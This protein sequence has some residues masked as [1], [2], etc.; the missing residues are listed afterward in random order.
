LNTELDGHWKPLT[1]AL[2]RNAGEGESFV[3]CLR[4]RLTLVNERLLADP[5]IRSKLRVIVQSKSVSQELFP[6]LLAGEGKG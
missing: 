2:S 6:R 5:P 4:Y 3:G 1:P